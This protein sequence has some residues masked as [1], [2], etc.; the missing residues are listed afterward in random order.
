MKDAVFPEEE[1]EAILL[2][3]AQFVIKGSCSDWSDQELLILEKMG[4]GS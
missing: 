1:P 2:A 4:V 3:E